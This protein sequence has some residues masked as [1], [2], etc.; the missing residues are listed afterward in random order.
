MDQINLQIDSETALVLEGGGMRGVFTVGVLDNFLDRGL[1]FPYTI[2]VSAGAS[3]GLSFMSRQRGR[4]KKA[5]IDLL[6]QYQ[7]IGLKYLVKQ[8]NIMDFNLMFG[9]FPEHIIPY[10][11]ATY[12]A[13]PDR[14]E[15][16]TTNCVTG[17]P[18]YWEEKHDSQR[19]IDIVKASCSLPFV[20]PIA[21]VDGKPML[22]GG[23]TDSIPVERAFSQG[24]RKAV[25][26][27]TR[28]RGYRKKHHKFKI[29]PFI[30]KD[31]PHIREALVMR[32][33]V[34][35]QQLDLVE[36]LEDEGRITVIRPQKPVEVDRI[37]RDTRKLLALYNEGYEVAA[38]FTS[39]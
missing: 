21:Y 35:N 6:E 14:F 32:S 16:V 13:T 37:E 19:I 20:C 36:R 34:Y 2:G 29:P 24:Y 12:A 17:L 39:P 27:L 31:Y 1:H 4:A 8:R 11:Y 18:E 3:N 23:I 33:I 7:Y 10:D 30:Y 22:D 26:I 38:S 9:D 15:M 25:V 28:N 5:N